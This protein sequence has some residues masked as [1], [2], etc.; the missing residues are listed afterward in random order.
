MKIE[1]VRR[2][3]EDELEKNGWASGRHAAPVVLELANGDKL[4][5]SCDPEGNAPG[6]LFGENADG[7]P[8]VFDPE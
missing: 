1:N 6:A 3:T 4:F 8:F 5:P 7:E 2:M